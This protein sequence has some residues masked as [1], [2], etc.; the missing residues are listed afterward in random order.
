MK[1]LGVKV[2][3]DWINMKNLV[4][5]LYWTSMV[6][7]AAQPIAK[8]ANAASGSAI[9]DCHTP[10]GNWLASCDQDS[11]SITKYQSS[12]DKIL[13]DRMALCM[14]EV[15]CY[16]ERSDHGLK[17][18]KFMYPA[19]VIPEEVSNTNGTLTQ[20]GRSILKSASSNAQEPKLGDGDILDHSNNKQPGEKNDN[21]A[22][23]SC[24]VPPGSYAK[25]CDK[26]VQPYVSPD[27][28]INR[29]AKVCEARLICHDG[30]KTRHEKPMIV[31]FD[32]KA[33]SGTAE[34]VENCRA[35][36]KVGP[37]DNEC[38]GKKLDEISQI[39]ARHGQ[40]VVVLGA[41]R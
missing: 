26:I 29:V 22:L 4:K 13:G 2:N 20:N 15:D 6:Q 41:P 12:I 7:A 8:V 16:P 36:L 3:F 33:K 32:V 34:L 17:H 25:S 5:F 10:T 28:L 35:S 9:S 24:G 11:L 21:T 23:Q 40:E 31:Y 38:N 14:L 39:A 30:E 19:G 18:N 27:P 1:I 37:N